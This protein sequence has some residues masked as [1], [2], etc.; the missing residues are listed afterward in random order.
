MSGKIHRMEY[1][2]TPL[3]PAR[4][5]HA[6]LLSA[7]AAVI[8]FYSMP[9]PGTI[10]VLM[11]HRIGTEAD[12]KAE[13]NAITGEALERQM[14]F[15]K[16]FGYRVLTMDHYYEILSGKRKAAGRELLITFDDGDSSFETKAI[17][18]LE[19][20]RFPVTMFIISDKI[21]TGQDG[22]MRLE[23]ILGFQKKYPWLNFQSHSKTH[24]H[25]KEISTEQL[26]EEISVSR[27]ELEKL[28]GKPVFYF[29]YPYGEFT[30][31]S[32]KLVEQ[33]GYRAGFTTGH[34]RLNGTRENLFSTTRVKIDRHS[35]NL[36]IF[37][38]Y[39]SGIHQSIKGTREKIR[40]FGRPPA[41][42]PERAGVHG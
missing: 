20:Y 11:Y 29:S 40:N 30:P 18:I 36:L 14:A 23:T 28:L 39:I 33:A 38:Y 22:S 32:P 7:L 16:R 41:V 8:L 13:G 25:F 37:W 12:A 35:G 21:Q 26:K 3:L 6:L 17:P 31:G 15:L 19:K 27:T 42:T 4:I 10:P 34:K 5:V 1:K 2:K 24:P 9:F